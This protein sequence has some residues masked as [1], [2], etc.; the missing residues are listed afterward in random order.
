MPNERP[1]AARM[2]DLA[3]LAVKMRRAQVE[4][5]GSGRNSGA[6]AHARE[7]ERKF[8][9]EARSLLGNAGEV[10]QPGSITPPR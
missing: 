9:Q 1:Y 10:R 5:F 7:L 3:M 8:D 6:L 4:Y 2:T